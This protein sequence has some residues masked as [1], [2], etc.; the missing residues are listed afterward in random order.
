LPACFEK[1]NSGFDAS[2][3]RLCIFLTPS[4]TDGSLECRNAGGPELIGFWR[5]ICTSSH[6]ELVKTESSPRRRRERGDKSLIIKNSSLRPL[7]LCG[8]KRTFYGFIKSWEKENQQRSGRK[9]VLQWLAKVV[10]GLVMMFLFMFP[11]L[12]YASGGSV[13]VQWGD[14][15]GQPS[16]PQQKGDL[17][18]GPPDHAPA[19]GYRAK[20]QYRY[21][22]DSR[23]YF[24][25]SRNVYFYMNKGGWQMAASLPGFIRLS[26]GFVTLGMDSDRPYTRYDEHKAK[27]PPGQAKKDSKGKPGKK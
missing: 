4:R 16:Q 26:S 19:H 6:D 22:P 5:K 25:T 17:K 27:Y 14:K 24:D 8:E 20:H 9:M 3:I 12:C 1:I 23:V 18:N 7:R 15:A 2:V 10:V 21:Y 11:Y 13:T